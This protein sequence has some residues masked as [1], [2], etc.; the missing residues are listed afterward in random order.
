MNYHRKHFREFAIQVKNNIYSNLDNP[1]NVSLVLDASNIIII[2]TCDY[3]TQTVYEIYLLAK[4]ESV[5]L[6][7]NVLT[8]SLENFCFIP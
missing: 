1:D 2:K 5:F 7:R 3:S 4:I 6:K 8:A